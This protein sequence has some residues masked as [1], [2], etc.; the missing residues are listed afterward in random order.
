MIYKFFFTFAKR[1]EREKRE[2][3]DEKRERERENKLSCTETLFEE[4]HQLDLQHPSSTQFAPQDHI[5]RTPSTA[6]EGRLYCEGHLE[7][8][9]HN[10]YR[11][12]KLSEEIRKY[13][14]L[15]I[16]GSQDKNTE[17]NGDIFDKRC[18]ICQ[19]ID[20]FSCSRLSSID[21]DNKAGVHECNE[22]FKNRYPDWRLTTQKKYREINI[23]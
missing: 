21:V 12:I 7:I 13:S 10:R 22:A 2:R 1:G 15:C 19:Y 8:G 5:F 20:S 23:E 4:L 18:S 14:S 6:L 17:R 11:F 3:K 9:L 16:F